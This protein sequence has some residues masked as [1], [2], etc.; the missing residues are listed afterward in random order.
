MDQLVF[1]Q[2]SPV[3]KLMVTLLTGKRLLAGVSALVYGQRLKSWKV[4]PADFAQIP[5]VC[6][7]GSICSSLQFFVL[8]WIVA[9]MRSNTPHS[10]KA[11]PTFSTVY[12]SIFSH[13]G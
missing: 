9:A 12:V 2:A 13:G 10:I 11:F 6:A 1:P 3:T 5:T 7:Y 4:L 8:I